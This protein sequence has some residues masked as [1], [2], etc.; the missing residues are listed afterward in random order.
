MTLPEKIMSILE[1]FFF[2]ELFKFEEFAE[3]RQTFSNWKKDAKFRH[4]FIIKDDLE[5]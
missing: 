1:P 3:T 5:S 4:D 2:L